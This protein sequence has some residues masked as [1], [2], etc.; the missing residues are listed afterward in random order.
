MTATS[1]ATLRAALG[2]DLP[3][4]LGIAV[5]GGSDSLAL[6]SLLREIP[7]ISLSVATV[8]HGLRPE[9]AT[10]ASHVAALCAGWGLEHSTLEW[11]AWDGRGNLQDTARRARYALLAD[12][13]R[14]LRLDAVALGHTRDDQAETVMMALARGAG[15]DGLSAMAARHER[16]GMVFLRPCLDISRDSLRDHLRRRKLAWAEDPGNGDPAF[17]RV[18]VRRALGTLAEAGIDPEKIADLAPRMQATRAALDAA[19]GVM[20]GEQI[21]TVAGAI[22]LPRAA[23]QNLPEVLAHRFCRAAI[24]WVSGRE[25]GIRHAPLSEFSAQACNGGKMT[26]GGC[27]VQS[28]AE[29]VWIFREAAAVSDH[30]VP[31]SQPWDGHWHLSGDVNDCCILAPLGANGLKQCNDWRAYG[32]PRA[33]CIALPGVWRGDTLL[34][35]PVLHADPDGRLAIVRMPD[36]FILSG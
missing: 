33:A 32:L 28:Q 25:R 17:E 19:L 8:D 24:R 22:R 9:A 36:N 1:D 12:W 18:R 27:V 20:L 15:V 13:A 29:T 14:M 35:A 34:C 2:A 4:R 5:S 10:E 16:H 3:A 6:L 31:V 21:E 30:R 26:L 7:E 11:R 23:L